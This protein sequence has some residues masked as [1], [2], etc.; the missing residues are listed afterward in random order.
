MR[1][2][3]L[4]GGTEELIIEYPDRGLDYLHGIK[5]SAESSKTHRLLDYTTERDSKVQK[6][7]VPDWKANG[8]GSIPCPPI[9]LGG[10]GNSLLELKCMFTEN[11]VAELVI[12]AEEIVKAHNLEDTSE[13]SIQMCNCCNSVGDI[14]LSNSQLRKAASR[15]DSSDNYLYNPTA[16]DI[17]H[18]DLKHFQWHW[19]RGQ[20]VLVSNV[21]ENALGLSWEPM[22]MWR[23]F[24]QITNTKHGQHL[25]VKAIDCLDWCEVSLV[26][27]CC[28]AVS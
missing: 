25:N 1:D 6:K 28:S 11:W 26:I 15:E 16:K 9:D 22:V 3:H 27:N 8:N 7:S 13:S 23:A 4:Q 12:K 19:A 20:P 17:Q 24:R 21:L 2:G 18:G 5:Y 14:N 10:C